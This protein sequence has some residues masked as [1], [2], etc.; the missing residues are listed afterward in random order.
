MGSSHWLWLPWK[1]ASLQSSMCARAIQKDNSV[2]ACVQ[3][4]CTSTKS[5]Q[6]A[7]KW[8]SKKKGEEKKGERWEKYKDKKGERER[9]GERIPCCFSNQEAS[10]SSLGDLFSLPS[11]SCPNFQPPLPSTPP[12]HS[13]FLPVFFLWAACEHSYL[14]MTAETHSGGPCC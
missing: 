8:Q 6:S 9:G 10:S 5:L 12:F 2:H 3:R 4:A 1:T 13:S 7:E 11:S 14:E